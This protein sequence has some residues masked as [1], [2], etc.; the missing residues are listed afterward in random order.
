MY[1]LFSTMNVCLRCSCLG[2]G[3]TVEECVT[4][5]HGFIII[6]IVKKYESIF[7]ICFLLTN[8]IIND[9]IYSRVN[10]I[11]NRICGFSLYTYMEMI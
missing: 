1:S 3:E 10:C 6:I 9:C 5:S 7:F 2:C 8:K 4:T 11:M